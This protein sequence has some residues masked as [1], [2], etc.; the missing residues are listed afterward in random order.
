M[1]RHTERTSRQPS[2]WKVAAAALTA[3]VIMLGAVL[4]AGRLWGSEDDQGPPV[5]TSSGQ[6]STPVE[7]TSPTSSSSSDGD[8]TELPLTVEDSATL[9]VP[10]DADVA[11]ES[12]DVTGGS[13]Y[14]VTVDVST[15]KPADSLGANIY[16]GARMTCTDGTDDGTAE[17]GGSE[18][19]LTGEPVRYSNQVLLTPAEDA[20]YTCSVYL[21]APYDT[22]ASKGTAFDIDVQWRANEVQGFVTQV[23]ASDR[24]PMTVDAGAQSM[25]FGRT[26]SVDEIAGNRI[27]IMTTLAVTTCS[28]EGGSQE[29]GQT[30]CQPDDIDITGSEFEIE[31]RMDVLGVDGTVCGSL[32]TNERKI[33]LDT[34]RHH[35]TLYLET[36][37]TIPGDLCGRQVR[38]ASVIVNSGPASLVVHRG[39][40]TMVITETGVQR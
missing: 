7:S 17:A 29:D 4:I 24:L 23:P 18:N 20:T 27:H 16:L 8:G 15:E 22:G 9:T 36:D 19:L 3:A 26:V 6:E 5:A 28:G 37:L 35:Q 1:P 14:V 13:N 10:E 31:T 2:W 39:N 33:S 40:S 34:Y 32:G 38:L 25:A 30:W 11:E 12:F 21:N